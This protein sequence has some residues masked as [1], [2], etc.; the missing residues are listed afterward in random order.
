[1]RALDVFRGAVIAA[2]ILVNS[3]QGHGDDTFPFLI[4]AAWNGWTFADT[5]FPAFLWIVGASMAISTQRR[6]EAGARR[7]HL[8]YHALLRA[9]LLFTLGVALEA[10]PGRLSGLD[11]FKL[12]ALQLTGVL[13][14]IAICYLAAFLIFLDTGWWTRAVWIAGLYLAYLGLMLFAPGAQCSVPPWTPDCNFAR[15]VDSE[16]LG[17]HVWTTPS[18]NDPEGVMPMLPG[19][20]S[21]LFGALAG[22]YLQRWSRHA[23]LLRLL[24]LGSALIVAGQCVALWVPVN[25]TL[26]TPSFSLLMAGMAT[27]SYGLCH[28]TVEMRALGRRL[29]PLDVLG[30][31]ALA[32]FVISRLGLLKVRVM[33]K[34]LYVDVFQTI[35][36]PKTASLLFGLSH[37]LLILAVAWWMYRRRWFW[38]L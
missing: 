30:R 12:E 1:L 38:K 7:Q 9:A 19:T 33:G 27:V 28:W 6:L 23:S 4:H 21:V 14:K 25:K 15:F 3:V 17:S 34:S 32:A 18:G 20:A 37:V 24:L 16:L 29:K 31:N 35:A 8:V 5:I 2:M 13:Q 36:S 22:D 10:W 11:E 26:W